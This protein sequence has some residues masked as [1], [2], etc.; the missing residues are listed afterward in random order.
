MFARSLSS[1]LNTLTS[2]AR[3]GVF[4]GSFDPPHVGH[5]IVAKD[6]LEQLHLDRL[7][8]IPAGVPPHRSVALPASVRLDLAQKMFRGLASIEVSDLE[9]DLVKPAYTIDTLRALVSRFP[10][11]K[12]VLVMGVDQFS[13]IDTWKD[14]EK[15][16]E[17][18]EIAVMR[19][20]GDEPMRSAR[21]GEIE[22]I[23]VDVMRMDVSS[24]QVR[25]R[26]REGRSIRFLVPDSILQD[27][28]RA[29]TEHVPKQTS[30]SEST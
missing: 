3:V 9:Q 11:S 16:P 23:V 7:L 5:A 21:T 6:L 1:R 14:F 19:R 15:L 27:I 8:V 10:D 12:F 17:L 28:E 30:E 22:Y 29:W 4:G 2:D 25:Q 20:D 24:S 18:A 26:L 13:V